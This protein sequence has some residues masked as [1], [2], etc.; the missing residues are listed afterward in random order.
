MEVPFTQYNIDFIGGVAPHRVECIL[1]LLRASLA[2]FNDEVWT[3]NAE[4][5]MS[6]PVYCSACDTFG[7]LT[8]DCIHF[9]GRVRVEDGPLPSA[10]HVSG[11]YV[12]Q[13]MGVTVAMRRVQ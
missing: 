6:L 8:R 10:Q 2:L 11:K 9:Q 1:D 7:H 5:L 4:V 12:L 3:E 13:K